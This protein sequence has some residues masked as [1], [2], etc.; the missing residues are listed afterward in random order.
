MLCHLHLAVPTGTR[1]FL[2]RAGFH[3]LSPLLLSVVTVLP[4]QVSLRLARCGR[5]DRF[6]ERHCEVDDS[7]EVDS[8]RDL[9]SVLPS[10][11]Y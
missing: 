11:V 6:L 2:R 8:G 10:P 7:K 3:S 1:W 9:L 5:E 4:L